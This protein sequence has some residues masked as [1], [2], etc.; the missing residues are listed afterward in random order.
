[1]LRTLRSVLCFKCAEARESWGKDDVEMNSTLIG[2]SEQDLDDS[3]GDYEEYDKA[4]DETDG[5]KKPVS[6]QPG[7]VF[8]SPKTVNPNE[9]GGNGDDVPAALASQVDDI[10]KMFSGDSG[11][12]EELPSPMKPPEGGEEPSTEAVFDKIDEEFENQMATFV[13][14]LKDWDEVAERTEADIIDI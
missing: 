2:G 7:S 9:P 5:G 1:M 4:N 3:K 6:Q 8:G 10:M 14:S 13:G 12:L 11:D